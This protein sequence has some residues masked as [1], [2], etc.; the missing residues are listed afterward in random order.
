MFGNNK[1][2]YPTPENLVKQMIVKIDGHPQTILEPSAGKGD[3]ID[4]LTKDWDYTWG[5]SKYR[6]ENV[7]AIE[8]DETLQ[9]TL[10]GKHI[11]VID[12]DFLSYSG[13]DKFDL[14]IGNPPFDTGD[15]HLL[16]AIDV[17]YR[18]QII[19]LLNA[20][21]LRNPHTNTRK[22]LVQKLNELNADIEYIKDAFVD[23]ERK[24]GVEVALIS[25]IVKRKVEDDLFQGCDDKTENVK[26]KLETNHE[27]STGKTI[28]EL[29]L[30]YNQIVKLCTETIIGYYRNFKKVGKYI[31]LNKE[32]EKHRYSYSSSADNE[33]EAEAHLTN[34]MQSTLNAMLVSVRRDFWQRTL[35]IPEV[36][37]RLTSKKRNEFEHQI[38][39]QCHMDFTEHNIRQ[40]IINLIGSYEKT[41]TEAVMDTFD[42]FTIRHCY[43][44]GLYDE[45]IH[46][47]NGW[48]TNKAFKVG[49]KVIIPMYGS[50]DGAF[51]NWQG[52]WSLNDDTA[53]QLND[54]DK[55]MNYF[56]GMDAYY[57]MHS[58]IQ[59]AFEKGVNKNIHSTYFTITCYKKGTI[60]LTFNDEGILRRFNVVACKGKNWLPHDYGTKIYK[61]M[62]QEE[63]DVVVSFEGVGSY[64]HN[65]N[66]PLFASHNRVALEHKVA[67]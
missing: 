29:V 12:A 61:D 35:D 1:N 59:R 14:I 47:F 26:P 7:Y 8:I 64:N 56:D 67:A 63:K 3:I 19:F 39:E 66:R 62:P 28:E 36:K 24:T 10:R 43:S 25:I 17:L 38:Q 60:H 21:T 50:Y 52:K 33:A 46:Y 2:F 5:G 13:P 23:A 65:L 20:E 9:A 42:L 4:I 34:L 11:K 49:K 18:G 44:S 55:V 30:E 40:F 58:A 41:L 15:L 16:K 45:N 51:T 53:R 6:L 31:G 27:V 37:N 57:S 32:A 54:I 22:V 48:K